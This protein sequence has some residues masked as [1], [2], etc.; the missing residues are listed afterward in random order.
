MVEIEVN[1]VIRWTTRGC[2]PLE[3]KLQ[4]ELKFVD[5]RFIIYNG[6]TILYILEQCKKIKKCL[7]VRCNVQ[8]DAQY[9]LYLQ[10]HSSKKF[11]TSI[12]RPAEEAVN[13][14]SLIVNTIEP[15]MPKRDGFYTEVIIFEL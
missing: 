8:N 2:N 14:K 7:K 9:C 12:Y 6:R 13:T 4:E 5:D 10:R 11:K 15:V 1:E 3:E